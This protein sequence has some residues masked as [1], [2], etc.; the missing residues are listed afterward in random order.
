[1]PTALL[2]G[3]L[4]AAVGDSMLRVGALMLTL[5]LFCWMT[6]VFWMRGMP[7]LK[8]PSSRPLWV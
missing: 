6:S 7:P 1:M 8:V 3:C 5:M 2:M 4:P